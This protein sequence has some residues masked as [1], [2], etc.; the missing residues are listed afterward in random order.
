MEYIPIGFDHVVPDGLD[1]ILFVVG[2]FLLSPKLSTLLWQVTA[3]TLAHSVTLIAGTLG[4]ISVPASIVEPLIAASIVFIAVENIFFA[5]L[6][7][8][9]TAIVFAFGLLHGLGFASV[10]AEFGLPAGQYIPALIGFNLGVE[11]GQLSVIAFAFVLLALP[12]GRSPYYRSRISIP[13]SS[14]IAIIGVWWVL[15][16]TVLS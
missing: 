7:P 9:R 3:F 13:I 14:I 11:F 8:W 6:N 12:F 1:H 16:R 5:T 4:A 10:L 15:E 2:L